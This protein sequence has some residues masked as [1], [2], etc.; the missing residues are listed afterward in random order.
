MAKENTMGNCPDQALVQRAKNG[1][2]DALAQ[3]ITR[4]LPLI[5]NRAARYSFVGLEQDDFV[6]EGLIGLFTAV[7]TM[8]PDAVLRFGPMPICVFIHGWYPA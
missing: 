1:D 4:F 7:K 3:L 2:T 8:M 5:K 6:Q